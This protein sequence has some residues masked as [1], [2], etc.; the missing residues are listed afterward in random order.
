MFS[1]QTSERDEITSQKF[2][3]VCLS[4]VVFHLTQQ[5]QK[6]VC[7]TSKNV[8]NRNDRKSLPGQF[9]LSQFCP[10]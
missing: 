7:D 9:H 5:F 1:E 10:W 8:R 3:M 2:I 4:P 6:L